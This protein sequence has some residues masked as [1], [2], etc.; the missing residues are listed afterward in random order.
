MRTPPSYTIVILAALL[1]RTA[2]YAI[3][4]DP[5]RAAKAIVSEYEMALVR[6]TGGL[7]ALKA[8][9]RLRAAAVT[10]AG[11][12]NLN[13]QNRLQNRFHPVDSRGSRLVG[14]AEISASERF[15]QVLTAV[16]ATADRL[17]KCVA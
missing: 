8:F 1:S 17:D 10:L 16:P 9:W 14:E 12:G 2:S 7:D 11:L 3:E 13:L 4:P 6:L 5:I 15:L